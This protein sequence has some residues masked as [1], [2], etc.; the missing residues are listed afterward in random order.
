[1]GIARWAGWVPGQYP[2]EKE[3]TFPPYTCLETDG[4]PRVEHTDRG[5]VVVFPLK[6]RLPS[7]AHAR[8]HGVCSSSRIW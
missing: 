7:H 1:M 6:V 2:G 4:E 5:E 8:I 3:V